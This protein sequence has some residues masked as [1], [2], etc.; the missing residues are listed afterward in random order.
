MPYWMQVAVILLLVPCL[1]LILSWLTTYYIRHWLLQERILD[2]P[3]A[4]SNHQ[5]P[6]PRGGGIAV[7]GV[8]LLLWAASPYLLAWVEV[9]MHTAD[10]WPVWCA[11]L[12]LAMVSWMDD[13]G[14]MGIV[15][16]LL[17]QLVAVGLGIMV[18]PESLILGG[19]LP[20]WLESLLLAL[21]WLWFINLFNF[22]DGIDGLTAT[23]TLCICL[24]LWLLATQFI[25]DSRLLVFIAI[26]GASA[27]GFLWW[28][29][30]PATIFLGD[31]GSVPLG[32]LL[33]F[34]LL[35]VASYDFGL[36]VL[37][38]PAYYVTDATSTL[39][40]RLVTRQRIWE[41]HSS[42]AYQRA[43]RAGISH[44]RVVLMVAITHIATGAMIAAWMAAYVPPWQVMM[45]S[46]VIAAGLVAYFR[47]YGRHHHALSTP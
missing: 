42:H 1:A 38:I 41:A 31:V 35:M 28:N 45:C 43:V 36:L 39:I 4:R 33:G 18:L 9:K 47:L 34:L 14:S 3:N 24:L 21:A 15:P 19:L 22:M 6:V 29:W 27:T 37:A 13:V 30:Q 46:Y 26:V 32:Y 11:A 23:V 25:V 2:R 12:L 7:V 10:I 16:R 8:V 5:R 17:A 20:F 44:R 40:W